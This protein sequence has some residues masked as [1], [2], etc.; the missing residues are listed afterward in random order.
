MAPKSHSEA[1]VLEKDE[2]VAEKEIN[3]TTVRKGKGRGDRSQL[4]VH[5]L[6]PYRKWGKSLLVL[7]PSLGGKGGNG[8]GSL[9]RTR[10]DAMYYRRQ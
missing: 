3:N 6:L 7:I 2:L 8:E 9:K 4:G 5:L 10:D 1:G